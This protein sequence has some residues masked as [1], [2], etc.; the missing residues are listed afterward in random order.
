MGVDI[1]EFRVYLIRRIRRDD[2]KCREDHRENGKTVPQSGGAGGKA[3][4]RV[5]SPN[6]Q[7]EGGSSDHSAP[8]SIGKRKESDRKTET[9]RTQ[10]SFVLSEHKV[11]VQIKEIREGRERERLKGPWVAEWQ[12]ISRRPRKGGAGLR[13]QLSGKSHRFPGN[14]EIGRLES[15][16]R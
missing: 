7:L 5:G 15:L 2:G 6:L 9:R 3:S 13:W 12:P 4:V 10:D 1:T 11:K 8:G 14:N 16:R